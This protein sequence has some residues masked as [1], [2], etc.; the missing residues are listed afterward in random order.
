MG[1]AAESKLVHY[2]KNFKTI[3]TYA[4]ADGLPEL[5][6]RG[7]IAD[8]NGDIWFHT[9]W[10]INQLNVANGEVSTLTENDGFEKQDFGPV[11]RNYK[12]DDGDIYFAGGIFGSGFNRITPGKYT[13][14]PSSI[15]LQSLEINQK[16]FPLTTGINNLTELSLRYNENK[17]T[18]QT[19][20]IDDYSKGTSH[21]RYKLE[22]KGMNG[23]WQYGPANYTIR[24]EGLQPGNYTLRIQ[25]SNAALQFN[26]P[27]KVL[28]IFISPP[29]WQTWWAYVIFI[30]AI[31]GSIWGFIY[32][33]SL[34]LLKE[35]QILEGKVK[36]RTKQLSEANEE[37][38]EQQEEI[39]TQRD[40]LSRT[41]N[42]LKSTQTQLIQS[43]KMAS[44]G[45]TTAGI[46]HEIQNP[47]NFVNNFSDV[48]REILEELK[49]ESKKPKAER[50]E[51]LESELISDLLEN[52]GK[53][54][55]PGKRADAIV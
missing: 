8:N 35:K 52:E 36:V 40:E 49:A 44:L 45:E 30:L 21:M 24:F 31:A 54:N 48:N 43:E 38:Q 50:D 16:P 53:I 1:R 47:L 26:G 9:D 28:M 55:H 29:W 32:Y 11:D 34:S 22:G 25:A 20:I 18:I 14:P 39:T 17:I 33:R 4:Q 12:D 2:N 41:V 37:L 5:E 15:Y 19:G 27:E 42:D 6:I 23:S 13:N 51:A 7:L 10:S 3:H 46:A